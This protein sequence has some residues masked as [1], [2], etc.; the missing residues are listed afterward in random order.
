MA[1]STLRSELEQ[2]KAK[3]ISD[4]IAQLDKSKDEVSH[5]ATMTAAASMKIGDN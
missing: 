1:L 5:N 3:A 4:L 2:D